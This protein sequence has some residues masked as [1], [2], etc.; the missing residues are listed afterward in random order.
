MVSFVFFCLWYGVSFLVLRGDIFPNRE[1]EIAML[2]AL[3]A[4]ADR[5]LLELKYKI[6]NKA[7]RKIKCEFVLK[8]F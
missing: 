8:I 4:V 2:I 1:C 7:K 3:F 5:D 6:K